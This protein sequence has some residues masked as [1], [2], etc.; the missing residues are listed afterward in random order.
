MSIE[1]WTPNQLYRVLEDDRLNPI[2]SYFLDNYFRERFYSEDEEIIFAK[3]PG[4]DRKMAPFVLPTMQGK[5]IFT[6]RGETL[7]RFKPPYIK[8]KDAVRPA[9][10]TTR[11]VSDVLSGAKSS[12]QERFDARVVEI[13]NVHRRAIEMQKAYLAAKAFIDAKLT[14]KYEFDQGDPKSYLLDFKRDAG[15]TVTLSGQFW[16]DPDY[17]I[18]ADV[19]DWMNMMSL[20][21]MG[22]S[23]S[24]M[25]VGASVAPLFGRNT[26]LKA[27]MDT[28]YRGN[29]VN[30]RTGLLRMDLQNPINRIG[31]LGA[32]LE[33]YSYR[34]TVQNNDGST[35]ELF[36]PKSIMLIAPGAT[37]VVAHGAIFDA[38]AMAAGN[39]A[40]D[41]YPKMWMTKD[42]GEVY[43]MHQSAPLPIP[44]YPNRTMV[45]TVLA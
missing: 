34:D 36:N 22:G 45:A 18:L 31:S 15:H 5:P 19:Q 42:P 41:I 14:I 40:I 39:M 21:Y 11:L 3:L 10:V 29:D 16:D 30:V 23:P 13:S 12:L 32:G 33:V 26:K 20:A 38:E 7:D 8:P 17:D 9:D 4:L 1:L 43:V 2:P 37:G 6:A 27:E 35:V 44:L 25:L 24:L 28:T